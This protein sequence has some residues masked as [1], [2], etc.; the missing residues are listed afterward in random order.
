[1]NRPLFQRLIA[2][3]E[4]RSM[5]CVVIYMV[6]RFSR[7]LMNFARSVEGGFSPAGLFEFADLFETLSVG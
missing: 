3:F 1:M 2:T 5:D 7:S 6:D 4:S